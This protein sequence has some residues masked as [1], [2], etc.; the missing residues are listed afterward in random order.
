MSPLAEAAGELGRSSPEI[1]EIVLLT[2]RVGTSGLLLG[3]AAGVPVGLW[4]AL[5]RFPGRRVLLGFANA[6]M[7]LPPVLAGLVVALLL[8]RSGPLGELELMYTPSAMIL[9]QALIATPVIV[10]L[11]AAGIQQ[12]G[13]E[14]PGQLRALGA[15]QLQLAWLLLKEARLPL[16]AAAMAAAGRLI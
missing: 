9:A 4:L 1:G 2:L 13:A 6:G 12:L 11:T 8:W 14:L 3:L 16:V 15:S 10:S 5:A 7:G